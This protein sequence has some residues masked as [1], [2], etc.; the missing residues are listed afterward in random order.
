M[1]IQSL[2]TLIA[3]DSKANDFSVTLH[4][5]T[6]IEAETACLRAMGPELAAIIERLS[7][8]FPELASRARRA[9]YL[10]LAGKVTVA[11]LGTVQSSNGRYHRTATVLA[12]V[13]SEWSDRTY[14]L[15][16][17]ELGVVICNCRD[18]QPEEG[19]EGAP[20]SRVAPHTCRHILAAALSQ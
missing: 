14:I 5:P 11:P 2:D 4:W 3:Y 12:W 15:T 7:A 1:T 10:V 13:K 17:G 9:G 18:A 19:E 16:R 20:R 6:R 8:D